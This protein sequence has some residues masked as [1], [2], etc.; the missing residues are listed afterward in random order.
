MKCEQL[1][2]HIVMTEYV[3]GRVLELIDG[4]AMPLWNDED[5]L[6]LRVL[7]PIEGIGTVHTCLASE[8]LHVDDEAI[9][10]FGE[11]E[12]SEPPEERYWLAKSPKVHG[13]AYGLVESRLGED[14]GKTEH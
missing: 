13:P 6:R 11:L 5:Y 9:K 2:G 8:V 7:A 1:I 3:L 12:A 14:D 4:R 10:A